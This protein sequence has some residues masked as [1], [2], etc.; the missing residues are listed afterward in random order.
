MHRKQPPHP[1]K[2]LCEEL[3]ERN[4]LRTGNLELE[5]DSICPVLFNNA[6]RTV[7][8]TWRIL[9]PPR[10]CPQWFSQIGSRPGGE[11][12]VGYDLA[13]IQSLIDAARQL[14]PN[15]DV[16]IILAYETRRF[17]CKWSRSPAHVSGF[18]LPSPSR[19]PF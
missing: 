9:S 4:I 6:P 3:H 10:L 11:S 2:H 18:I 12:E 1:R 19:S 5:V 15:L 13:L 8:G 16:S 7:S 14:S 17:P